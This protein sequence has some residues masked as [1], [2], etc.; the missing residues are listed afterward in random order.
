VQCA[1][2]LGW[3]RNPPASLICR[4]FWVSKE[5]KRERIY[6]KY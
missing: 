6:C 2:Q 3:W 1:P 4:M 5:R